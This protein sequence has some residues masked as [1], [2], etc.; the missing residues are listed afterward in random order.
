MYVCGGEGFGV[1]FLVMY[2]GSLWSFIFC[3]VCVWGA[4]GGQ[5]RV[6]VICQ[7]HPGSSQLL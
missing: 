1:L 7:P 5:K 4:F 2:V 3:Y 6:L